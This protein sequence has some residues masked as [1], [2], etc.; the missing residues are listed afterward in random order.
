MPWQKQAMKDVASCDKPVSYTHLDVYKR[1]GGSSGEFCAM[2]ET[3]T[4]QR[5][6]EDEVPWDVKMCIRD[7]IMGL[8]L[9]A[10]AMQFFVNGDLVVPPGFVFAMGDNRTKSLDGRYW[11]FVPRENIV[12]RPMFVYWSF[13]TLS[14]I[15]I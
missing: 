1:Q 11:G 9:V 13:Q 12:G 14:L 4:Q 10:L 8:L 7:S 6:V 5:R 15:H 2:G 3:L